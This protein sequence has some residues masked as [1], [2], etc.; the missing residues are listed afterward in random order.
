MHIFLII[1]FISRCVSFSA[2]LPR[3]RQEAPPSFIFCALSLAPLAFPL[4]FILMLTNSSELWV[5][6]PCIY[7]CE[8]KG[9]FQS[10]ESDSY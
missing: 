3:E 9:M 2:V 4:D 7:A 10:F 5:T 1:Q 8:S 6:V